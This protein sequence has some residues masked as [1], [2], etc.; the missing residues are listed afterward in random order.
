V[1]H[2][3][4]VTLSPYRVGD[5]FGVA[6]VGEESGV[7]LETASGPAWTDSRGYVVLPSLSGFRRSAV[8]IDTRS[9]ARNVDINNAWQETDAARGSI[10]YVNFDV[11]RTRR[12]LATV[13]DAR[14]YPL[15]HGA[16]VF[17]SGGKFVTVVGENGNVFIP[18]VSLKG[19]MGVQSSGKT[20]CTFILSLPEKAETSKLYETTTAKCR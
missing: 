17:D 6:K 1:A 20:L 18:D 11:V 16:S 5:T 13:T 9:L 12:V 19:I 14:G 15:S 10:N 4:G 7:R 2:D 8:Q 3:Y